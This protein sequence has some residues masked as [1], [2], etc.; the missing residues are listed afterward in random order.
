MNIGLRL[1]GCGLWGLALSLFTAASWAAEP[2]ERSRTESSGHLSLGIGYV[3][4]RSLFQGEQAIGRLFIS[5]RYQWKGLFVEYTDVPSGDRGIPTIGFNFYSSDHWYYDVVAAGTD[6][7]H[8]YRLYLNGEIKMSHARDQSS[9]SG[10]RATGA[11]G[12]NTLQFVVLPLM[13][14]KH[15]SGY[16]ASAWLARDWQLKNW[17]FQGVLGAQYRS[18]EIMDYYYG[19]SEAEGKGFFPAYEAKAGTHYSLQLDASYPLS[20]HWVVHHYV[21]HVEYPRS[22]KDSP[23]SQFLMEYLDRP[24]GET[25]VGVLINFVF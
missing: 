14:G 19:Y 22:I 24:S 17:T 11:Y 12:D 7:A 8:S 10:F 18:E 6:H 20:R 2:V 25:E 23:L 16:Y 15:D 13:H 5:G 4:S 1:L 21:R 3:S 9:G